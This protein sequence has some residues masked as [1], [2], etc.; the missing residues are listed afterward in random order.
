MS[1][2]HINKKMRG[3][4]MKSRLLG[5][6]IAM[7]CT[8][9]VFADFEPWEDYEMSDSVYSVTTVKVKPNMD[10]AYLEG[11]AKTWAATNEKAKE[12]GQI[13]DYSIYRSQLPQSGYFSVAG[14]GLTRILDTPLCV[15]RKRLLI[16]SAV[17]LLDSPSV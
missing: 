17:R 14:S 5:G 3:K 12:L 2:S 9:A 13:V 6:V 16:A 7:F 1:L 4:Q 11:I 15:C 10:D 8:T